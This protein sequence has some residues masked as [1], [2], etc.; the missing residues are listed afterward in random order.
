M[1]V[2]VV[3]P[4]QNLV[5]I[6]K[7]VIVPAPEVKAAAPVVKAAAPEVSRHFGTDR[8]HQTFRK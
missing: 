5:V 1:E 4:A 6:K 2:E 7:E 8:I 3:K